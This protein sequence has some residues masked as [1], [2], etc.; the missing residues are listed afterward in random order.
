M[1]NIVANGSDSMV[2]KWPHDPKYTGSNPAA[3]T[4]RDKNNILETRFLE[5]NLSKYD[6]K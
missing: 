2:R 5:E 1:K 6:L 4:R 3:G